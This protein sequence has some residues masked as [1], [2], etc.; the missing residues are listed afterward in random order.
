MASPL[1]AR[2]SPAAHQRGRA[3]SDDPSR[4]PD[5]HL[6]QLG[7]QPAA[8]GRAG[9]GDTLSAD[10]GGERRDQPACDKLPPDIGPNPPVTWT[11]ADEVTVSDGHVLELLDTSL[12]LLLPTV[13]LCSSPLFHPKW[14]RGRYEALEGEPERPFRGDG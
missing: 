10:P 13:W 5:D 12:L 8:A 3:R 1:D 4:R 11:V 14:N 6:H 2:G 7:R 9:R